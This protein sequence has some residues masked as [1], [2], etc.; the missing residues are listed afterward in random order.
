MWAVGNTAVLHYR[1][2]IMSKPG[3]K[4]PIV[5]IPN[6]G[7]NN[8]FETD[9]ELITQRLLQYLEQNLQTS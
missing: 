3:Y 1:I 6:A 9:P 8:L 2:S 5:L 4:L 7:H